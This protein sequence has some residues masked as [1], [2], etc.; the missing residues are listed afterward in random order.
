[1]LDGGA[2]GASAG[3]T[4][5]RAFERRGRPEPGLMGEPSGDG[6]DAGQVEGRVFVRGVEFRGGSL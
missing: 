1:M 2:M 4:E 3:Q 6:A 5:G